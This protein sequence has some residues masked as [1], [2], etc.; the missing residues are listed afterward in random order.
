MANHPSFLKPFEKF[1]LRNDSFL[2][3][4]PYAQA[5]FLQQVAEVVAVD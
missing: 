1:F 3:F 5:E 2:G 4:S